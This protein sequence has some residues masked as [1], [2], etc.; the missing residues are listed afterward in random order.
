MNDSTNK[1]DAACDEIRER[2]AWYP[3]EAVE[4]DERRKL[5]EH[6]ATCP[7]CAQLLRLATD[8]KSHLRENPP[9]L[10]PDLLTRALEDA[11]SLAT[12]ERALVER[13]LAACP[14]CREEAAI[15]QALAQPVP[16]GWCT[17]WDT[18]ARTLLRPVPAAIYL[19]AAIAAVVF[20]TVS[21]RRGPLDAIPSPA[22]HVDGV[23]IL[24]DMR[25]QQRAPGGQGEPVTVLAARQQHFLL[26]EF[27]ALQHVPGEEEIFEL[28]IL[29]EGSA[30]L[31]AWAQ[32]VTGKAFRDTY[33]LGLVVTPGML[34]PGRYELV[35]EDPLGKPIYRSLIE[36][37]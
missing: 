29:E 21:P 22:D 20:L 19:T 30:G 13:H 35:V 31:P 9:H 10:D 25:A 8:M 2:I 14:H 34:A 6:A 24:S 4:E 12:R 26:L 7:A 17:V 23:V 36:V 32:S 33:T 15:L 37:Q 3:T 11:D 18:L 16:P 1:P 28:V 27:L 5:E